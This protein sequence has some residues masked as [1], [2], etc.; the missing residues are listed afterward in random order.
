M[1]AE[2]FYQ[3]ILPDLLNVI[4]KE[5]MPVEDLSLEKRKGFYAIVYGASVLARI[6]LDT[7]KAAPFAELPADTLPDFSGD[8]IIQARR[9]GMARIP[10]EGNSGST[11][12]LQSAIVASLEK[13]L[14]QYPKKFDCCSRYEACSNAKHCIH[15]DR[16]FSA[17]CGY[18]KILNSG[19]IFYGQNKNI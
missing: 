7:K 9:E 6:K 5:W 12:K 15:P 19:K 11:L 3:S 18:R 17:D 10:L 16:R 8:D 4:E 2:Q 14:K 13:A 1:N